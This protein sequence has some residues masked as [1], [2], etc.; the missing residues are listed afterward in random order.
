MTMAIQRELMLNHLMSIT[1]KIL[2]L[3]GAILVVR[4]GY[5]ALQ[6]QQGRQDLLRPVD[7]NP[8]FFH[9]EQQTS[10]LSG[11][12]GGKEGSPPSKSSQSL[13]GP[14]L[15]DDDPSR[16][17]KPSSKSTTSSSAQKKT[18][19]QQKENNQWAIVYYPYTPHAT[20]K[21][22]LTVRSDIASIRAHGFRAVRLHASD[23]NALYTVGSAVALHGMTL[24]LGVHIDSSPGWARA[25]EAGAGGPGSSVD[26]EASALALAEE[27]ITD[28]ITWSTDPDTLG[29]S[30]IE[31]VVVGEETVFNDILSA[32]SLAKLLKTTRA[33]LRA[34]GY[35]GL[36]TT[37][38][39]IPTL[40]QHAKLLCPVLDILA[41]NIHPF[42]SASV[43]AVEAGG[44]VRDALDVL[45]QIC[46]VG[47]K[48]HSAEE[49]MAKPK[50]PAV[51]L[52]TGWPTRGMVN[53]VAR[54]GKLEQA[55]AVRGIVKLAG[56]RSVIVGW[57]DDVWKEEGD[58]GVERAWG[59]EG[60]FGKKGGGMMEEEK[61]TKGGREDVK[62]AGFEDTEEKEDEE[63]GAFADVVIE[64][65][66]DE[67]E[68]LR[69]AARRQ[70]ER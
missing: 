47:P 57:G 44:Y 23:C 15:G 3:L 20:C 12:E 18:P 8:L 66:E 60:L 6:Q 52:E 45:D 28:L 55:E 14:P 9:G 1:K 61:G 58:L 64:E 36:V 24:I 62:L 46:V 51:N 40:Y 33:R 34:E 25:R 38:E 7:N 27:Q 59:C 48:A 11:R 19:L 41:S 39:P 43:P 49:R 21:T 26:D 13:F 5:A 22:A 65:D 2:L 31:L 53:G 10:S 29:W 50:P 67:E 32:A 30:I 4:S 35:T 68:E 70:R 17:R 37:T 63:E 42:F 56:R 16:N 69:R 54:P